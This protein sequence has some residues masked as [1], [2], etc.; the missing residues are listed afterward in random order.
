MRCSGL[1][2]YTHADLTNEKTTSGSLFIGSKWVHPR[3]APRRGS[4]R[5]ALHDCGD[6][7]PGAV[8]G[9]ALLGFE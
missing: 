8:V 7:Q 4:S 6:G 5:P 9:L 2:L 3:S 1:A